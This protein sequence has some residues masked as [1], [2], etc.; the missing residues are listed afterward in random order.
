MTKKIFGRHGSRWV[1]LQGLY[2]WQLTQNQLKSIEVDLLAGELKYDQMGYKEKLSL[3]KAYFHELMVEISESFAV[4]DQ[5]IV[6]H[7]DRALNDV[8]PIERAILWIALYELKTRIEIPYKV[9]INEAILLAKQFGAKE[10]HRFV[11]GV[12]D[13]VAKKVRVK[14]AV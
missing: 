10:S 13:K 9:I 7:L 11:N 1:A 2:A 12:L 6:P 3:D 14:E 4:L 5:L 8:N